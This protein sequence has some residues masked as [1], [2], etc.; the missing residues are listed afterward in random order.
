MGP[1]A[2]ARATKQLSDFVKVT[3][4]FTAICLVSVDGKV[5]GPRGPGHTLVA[6][7]ASS[8]SQGA[9]SGC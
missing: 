2:K 3:G 5:E 7:L 1:E 4:A 6:N 8:Q 9:T